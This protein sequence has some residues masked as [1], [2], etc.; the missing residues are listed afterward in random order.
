MLFLKYKKI[1]KSWQHGRFSLNSRGKRSEY[2]FACISVN[3][4][5]DL[6]LLREY[7]SMV[8]KGLKISLYNNVNGV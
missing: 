3:G 1:I 5:S 8:R 4:I 7:A 6:S 2:Y